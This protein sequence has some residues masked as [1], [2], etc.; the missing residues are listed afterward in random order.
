MIRSCYGATTDNPVRQLV[1]VTRPLS[2]CFGWGLGMSLYS[3]GA[4]FLWLSTAAWQYMQLNMIGKLLWISKYCSCF[5]GGD[6]PLETTPTIP[7]QQPFKTECKPD[8]Q[9]ASL[10]YC[11][12]LNFRGSKFLWIAVFI[13]FVPWLAVQSGTSKVCNSQGKFKWNY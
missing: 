1:V 6:E 3:E 10:T 5:A 8:G 7:E 12:T 4:C 9:W 2:W 11:I 13:G